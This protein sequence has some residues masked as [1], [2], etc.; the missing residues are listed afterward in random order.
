M[1]TKKDTL[2]PR[3]LDFLRRYLS[4]D[5]D[6]YSNALQSA[7]AAGYKQ[8]YAEVI[9]Q[10]APWLSEMVGEG[11]GVTT[12]YIIQ[13]IKAETKGDRA[14]DRLKAY[15]LLGKS[16][17]LF[18]DRLEHSGEQTLKVEVVKYGDTDQN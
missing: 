4:P 2:D 18:T 14:R 13:G 8:E 17:K 3:Q 6:T 5:S 16:Q 15:E 7:L 12:D 9:L 10:R 11:Q 1:A